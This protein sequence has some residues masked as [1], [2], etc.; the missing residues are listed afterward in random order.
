MQNSYYNKEYLFDIILDCYENLPKI[1]ADELILELSELFARE[2]TYSD[3]F[4]SFDQT[5]I[6]YFYQN[7]PKCMVKSLL[8]SLSEL[9][10]TK[11]ERLFIPLNFWFSRNPGLAL[12]GLALQYHETRVNFEFRPYSELVIK[13]K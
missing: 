11:N 7:L 10:E 6:Y 8:M 12:P 1:L 13:N 9:L 2:Q 5:I 3:S 4:L